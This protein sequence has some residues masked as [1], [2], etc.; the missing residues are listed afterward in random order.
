MLEIIKYLEDMIRMGK[1][2]EI[3]NE[4]MRSEF[5]IFVD[6]DGY[7]FGFYTSVR[8]TRMDVCY[9]QTDD[10]IIEPQYAGFTGFKSD[11]FVA[12]Q[13]FPG[14]DVDEYKVIIW[15]GDQFYLIS[16][17]SSIR[18]IREILKADGFKKVTLER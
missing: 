13:Y 11:I 17:G 14:L 4:K 18:Y 3:P 5:G 7:D 15:D 1:A 9:L 10:Q 16:G 8:R 6:D 12:I 2:G